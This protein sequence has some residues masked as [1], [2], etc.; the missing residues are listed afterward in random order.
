MNRKKEKIHILK[1]MF[2]IVCIELILKIN[3]SYRNKLIFKIV[4][5]IFGFI[6]IKKKEV[7]NVQNIR[8]IFILSLVI[9]IISN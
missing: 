6:L 9:R 4:L 5:I 3:I 8:A 2:S 1:A 7:N